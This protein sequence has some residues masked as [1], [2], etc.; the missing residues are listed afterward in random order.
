MYD[1]INSLAAG[2]RSELGSPALVAGYV[3]G[4]YEWGPAEW[5]LFPH[6]VHVTISV[7]AAA[8]AGDVLDV[9]KGDA[10]PSQVLGWVE[11]RKASGLHRPTVYCARSVIPA[12]RR[13]TG[14]LLLG[15]DYDI[16]VADWTGVPHSVTAPGP[17]APAACAAVQYKSTSGW[18]VS[19]VEDAGWPHRGAVTAPAKPAGADAP[20]WPDGMVLREGMSGGPVKVLQAALNATGLYGVRNITVDGSFGVQTATSVRNFQ[21]HEGLAVDGAAGPLTR[22]KLGVQ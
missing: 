6:S 10:S 17:G 19:I 16:W 14:T 3:N 4:R 9:E 18:D 7:T 1:G 20:S 12:V 8:D 11:R 13:A 15:R 5:N 22:Q 21:A 2:I